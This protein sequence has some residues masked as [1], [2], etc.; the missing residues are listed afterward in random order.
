MS[1]FRTV[2]SSTFT[3]SDV[4]SV[5]IPSSIQDWYRE[6]KVWAKGGQYSFCLWI[7][8]IKNT[9]ILIKSTW[10][11][12][13]LHGTC[14]Q[15][16]RNIKTRCIG[17][18]TNLLKRKDWSSIRRDRTLSFFTTHSQLFVCR[19]LFGWKLGKSKTK[20]IY[21][22]PRMPPKISMK[23]DWMRELGW[24][25]ARQ[26]EVNQ[27]TQPNPNPNHDRTVR[28]VVT[29]QT[30]S[31]AREI[32]TRFSLDCKNTNLF[33]E[34]WEK[35]KDTDKNVDADHDRTGRPVVTEQTSSIA[36]EIDTRFSLDCKNTNLFVELWEKDKDTDKN[37][38][39]DHDRTGRPVVVRPGMAARIQRKSRGWQ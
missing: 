16:G 34:L 35:D 26:A 32:D 10:K 38:D 9:K 22:S 37:V 13:V 21:E 39:A 30:S 5:C 2:P 23:P 7:L 6:V 18:I 3:M 20:E 36:R 27:P 33:V 24:E 17:S 11:H 28:P 31:M 8:W 12:R 15:R 14:R 4:Q 29:E 25:V 1:L 19:K